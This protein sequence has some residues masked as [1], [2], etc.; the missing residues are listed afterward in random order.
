[1]HV[2]AAAN[3]G[4]VRLPGLTAAHSFS[5]GSYYNPD[6]MGFGPLRVINDDILDPGAGF[7]THPHDNMEIITYVLEGRLAHQ[8]SMGHAAEIGPGEVQFMSAG[9]GIRHSEFNAGPGRLRLL[10]IWVHPRTRGLEPRYAQTRL[11]ERA[12]AGWQ[13]IVAEDGREGAITIDQALLLY[14]A[15]PPAGAVLEWRIAGGRQVWL[16][17]AVGRLRAADGR[18]LSQG[19]AAWTT[20][21]DHWRFEA[22]EATDVLLFDI[23]R[24]LP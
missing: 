5:F 11:D 12:A 13:P 4:H 20:E 2:L 9:R 22:L 15:T 18:I 24:A 19:D 14:A 16:Q 1:M 8:D 23:A 7:P 6:A 3:R 21:P 10:Q 17:V